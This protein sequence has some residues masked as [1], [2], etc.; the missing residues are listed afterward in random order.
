[1]DPNIITLVNSHQMS[2]DANE[3]VIGILKNQFPNGVT[4]SQLADQMRSSVEKID[5]E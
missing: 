2:L 3:E 4:S 5:V 1:M